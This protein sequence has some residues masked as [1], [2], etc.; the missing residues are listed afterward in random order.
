MASLNDLP[1][2][3]L[4]EIFSLLPVRERVRNARV[5][6]RWTR[7]LHDPLM[8]RHV[9]LPLQEVRPKIVW[10]VLRRYIGSR[11]QSL[12]LQGYRVSRTTLLDMLPGFFKALNKKCPR[13]QRLSLHLANLF[14]IPMAS[15]PRTLRRLEIHSCDV[16]QVWMTCKE[17]EGVLPH[18]EQ[19]VLDRVPTFR[20]F[21][22]QHLSSFPALRSLVLAATNSLTEEGLGKGLQV[23]SH[24]QRIEVLGCT[25]SADRALQAIRSHLPD[26]RHIRV[27]IEGLSD[28]GLMLLE[29]IP[30]LESLGLLATT[31]AWDE[32]PFATKLLSSCLVLTQLR[33]LELQGQGWEGHEAEAMLKKGLPSCRVII[34]VALPQTMDWWKFVSNR[35]KS[36]KI[37]WEK[38]SSTRV[39]M[40]NPCGK[41][42]NSVEWLDPN[43]SEK[44]G[45][46]NVRLCCFPQLHSLLLACTYLLTSK[47]LDWGLL[48]LS[49]LQRI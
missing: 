29:G 44:D 11:L 24:L 7:L 43:G 45:Q 35:K 2:W 18:L 10:H 25:I 31:N 48:E 13:L 46:P 26:V 1:D 17:D 15:L 39:G 9:D 6:R 42:Q 36:N 21:H 5:C 3:V 8:W 16:S 33:V 38:L 4:V 12:H 27:T 28:S 14:F 19:L 41:R 34:G 37:P 47:G 20:D 49:H 22:L 40:R 23:L 30:T 32:C